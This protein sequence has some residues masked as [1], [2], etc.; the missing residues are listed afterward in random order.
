MSGECFYSQVPSE[1]IRM[2][3]VWESV[4]VIAS[5]DSPFKFLL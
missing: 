3:F 4:S 2:R 1:Y 5:N